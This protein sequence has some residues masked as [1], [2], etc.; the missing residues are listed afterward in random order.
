M[1]RTLVIVACTLG[2]AVLL[3]GAAYAQDKGSPAK[4]SVVNNGAPPP[5]VSNSSVIV[6][7]DG[8]GFMW[9]LVRQNDGSYQ[10]QLPIT[11]PTNW[12]VT[13]RSRTAGAF[14]LHA[15]NPGSEPGGGFCQSFLWEGTINAA[16]NVYTGP[17]YNEPTI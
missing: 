9:N 17:I 14:E 3:G 4:S 15:I 2:V 8:F 10:G 1:K 7:S 5:P 16:N 6:I 12:T 11:S 13:G